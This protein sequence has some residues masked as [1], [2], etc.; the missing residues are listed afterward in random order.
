LSSPCAVGIRDVRGRS[1]QEARKVDSL[2]KEPHRLERAVRTFDADL[3]EAPNL[4]ALRVALGSTMEA[5]Q[6]LEECVEVLLER[7]PEEVRS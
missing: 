5:L 4:R 2:S 6:E 1:L 7:T 3:H